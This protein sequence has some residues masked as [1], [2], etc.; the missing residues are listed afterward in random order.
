MLPKQWRTKY[1]NSSNNNSNKRLLVLQQNGWI[2]YKNIKTSQ[3]INNK[4]MSYQKP[5]IG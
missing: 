2:T 4:I 5:Q 1:K 3:A